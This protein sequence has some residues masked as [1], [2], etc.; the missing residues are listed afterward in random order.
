MDPKECIEFLI[1][2][3]AAGVWPDANPADFRDFEGNYDPERD[4]IIPY[5]WILVRERPPQARQTLREMAED[6]KA[7][8][9]LL[10]TLLDTID[11]AE[12]E[13]EE[14]GHPEWTRYLTLLRS[15]FPIEK[16]ELMDF[17]DADSIRMIIHECLFGGSWDEEIK[18]MEEQGS[19]EQKEELG[20][21]R[22]LKEFEER[23]GVEIAELLLTPQDREN[24]RTLY[25][26][27]KTGGIEAIR[28]IGEEITPPRAPAGRWQQASKHEKARRKKRK[29]KKKRK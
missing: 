8:C 24:N 15:P 29:R 5:Q 4:L 11:A 17:A 19:E 2:T 23:Y 14:A 9:E 13:A 12:K 3:A 25:E 18:W 7:G 27:Y 26:A 1:E 22:S 6:I 28:I 21:T 16:P 10:L 20:M